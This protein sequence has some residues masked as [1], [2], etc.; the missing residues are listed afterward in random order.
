MIKLFPP[1][2]HITL[3]QLSVTGLPIKDGRFIVHIHCSSHV[4]DTVV[5]KHVSSINHYKFLKFSLVCD[6]LLFIFLYVL[7]LC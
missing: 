7:Y 2:V 5:T 3:H 4:M 6:I 1:L